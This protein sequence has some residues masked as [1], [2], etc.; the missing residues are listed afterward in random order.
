[1]TVGQA[2]KKD[3]DWAVEKARAVGYNFTEENSPVIFELLDYV[4]NRQYQDRNWYGQYTIVQVEFW[5][6]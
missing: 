5:N 1:M 3:Q 6:E 2:L 4:F